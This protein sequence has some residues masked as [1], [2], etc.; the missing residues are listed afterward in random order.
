MI[1]LDDITLQQ[2]I[3]L[4]DRSR[5]DFAMK[6]AFKFTSPVEEYGIGDM[7]ALSFGTVKDFQYEISRGMG[8][9]R[10][11]IL[12]LNL[13]PDVN[14]PSEPLSKICRFFHYVVNSIAE[15][16][17]VEAKALAHSSTYEELQAGM[18]RFADLGIYLQIRTYALT[19]HIT[20]D[21]ARKVSYNDAFV[22]LFTQKQLNDYN[23]ELMRLRSPK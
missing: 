20:I 3:N 16:S 18:D 14:L 12:L 21:E 10:F 1:E 11:T 7:R 9:D 22:E 4:I 13:I 5:Y 17:E 23:E 19:F 6:Y 15:I 2:Y 8:F